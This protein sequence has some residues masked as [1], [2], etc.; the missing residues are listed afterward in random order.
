M[1][2]NCFYILLL[3]TMIHSS[4]NNSAQTKRGEN[5]DSNKDSITYK[6]GSFGYDLNFLKQH[7]SVVVLKDGET[8]QIIV[9]PKYQAKVFT[10]TAN[11][12]EGLSFGWVNY[13]AFT[14]PVDAHMNAYGGENRFW[15][16]PEGGKFSLFFKPGSKMVFENWK[17]PAPFDTEAWNVTDKSNNAV[18]MQKDMKLTN[19]KG[20]EMQLLVDRTIKMLDRQQIN[21]NTGLALDTAVKAVGYETV[22]VL[23]NKGTSEWTEATGMPCM[24]ILDMFKPTPATVIVVPFKNAAGQPFNKVA[25]TN[26]FGEIPAERLKHTDEVLYFKADGKSRGKLGIVPDKAKTFAGSYDSQNKV[27][28]AIMFDAEPEARYLNQEWNTTKPPFSGDAVNAYNDGPL[29][30]GSQMGPFYEIESVSPAAFLK[31]NQSLSHKQSVFHFTG[32]EQSLDGIAK[33]LFGVSIEDIKKA[34]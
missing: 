33:K 23:T 13:K 29:A 1:R 18:A 2:K 16:G 5:K 32:S 31:P 4:C 20:T 14:A 9:S 26:Y 17:T 30:D 7:D 10:S 15:L 27:L 21:N 28:T 25:T 3:L 19:Y 34:F 24:W 12:N 6:E 8:S 22:N 11:G